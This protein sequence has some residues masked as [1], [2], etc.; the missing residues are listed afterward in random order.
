MTTRPQPASPALQRRSAPDLLAFLRKAPLFASLPEPVLASLAGMA[1]VRRLSRGQVLFSQDDPPD[2]VYLLYS[3]AIAIVLST[4]D[5]RELVINEMRPGDSFGE[6]AL[7]EGRQRRTATA[8]AR[9]A[10]EVVGIPSAEFMRQLE[11]QPRL[12][13]QLLMTF[14]ERLRNSGERES[15]LAFLTAPARLARILLQQMQAADPGAPLASMSQEELAQH[16]GVTRQTVAKIL[17]DWRRAG[18][19]I[20]GRGKIMLVNTVAL[21]RLAAEPPQG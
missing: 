16:V 8:I 6:L 1:N 2:R 11:A 17:G 18:W 12:M 3:G 15:A 20:T 13:R 7:L 10:S 9:A 5:G 4:A 19:I 21:K 14:A